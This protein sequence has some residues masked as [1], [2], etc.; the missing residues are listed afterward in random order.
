MLVDRAG[1]TMNDLGISIKQV[2]EL[3]SDICEA[4]KEQGAGVLQVGQAVTHLDQATQQNASL[5]EEMAAA[6][7]SLN[8]QADGLV[9]A[10]GIF[11]TKI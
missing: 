4:S 9:A 5:V 8:S 10:V 7:G 11:K 3:M 6:S 1:I 2:I